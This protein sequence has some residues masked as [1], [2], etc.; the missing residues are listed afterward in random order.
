M[1]AAAANV[2]AF[3]PGKTGQ[4][5]DLTKPGSLLR[6]CR[7]RTIKTL[8]ESVSKALD[9]F[10]DELYE[11]AEQSL[12][13]DSRDFY[14]KAKEEW[15]TLRPRLEQRF[16]ER[17]EEGF[18]RKSRGEEEEPADFS[19]V[20]TAWSELSL[21]ADGDLDES[22]RFTDIAGRIRNGA[23]E[24]LA[25][26]DQRMAVVLDRPNMQSHDNPLS[27][28]AICDAFRS[29]M[30]VVESGARLKKLLIRYFDQGVRFPVPKLY[31]ELNGFLKEHGVLPTIR[32]GRSKKPVSGAGP[33]NGAKAADASQVLGTVTLPIVA[34][35]P[36]TGGATMTMTLPGGVAMPGMG[37][38]TAGGGI[39]DGQDPFAMLQQLMMGA[40]ARGAKGP[41]GA[42][43]IAA[44]AG[45][46]GV[47]TGMPGAGSPAGFG[48]GM[49]GAGG[50]GFAV[51]H[52]GG[53]GTGGLGGGAPGLGVGGGTAGGAPAAPDTGFPQ[54]DGLS[55]GGIAGTGGF[56]GGGVAG[57]G[58]AAGG[59]A[60]GGVAG[61][62]FTGGAL[63]G[64]LTRLQHGDFRAMPSDVPAAFATPDLSSVSLG[65]GFAAA[66]SLEA[67]AAPARNVL[68]ALKGTSFANQLGQM[69]TVTLDIVAMLFDQIFGDPRVPAAMKALIGRLQIPMLKVAVMDKNFFSK[70]NHPARH[71]LD[72]LGELSVGLGDGFDAG[73]ALYQRIESILQR[74]VE[75]FEEDVGIF[76]RTTA[77]L[78]ALI[79]DADK[80]AEQAGKKEARRIQDKE[81]LDVARL[82]AQN[83]VKA[84]VKN[85]ALPRA[86]L[87][88]LATEWMKLLILAY[89]KGGRES[90][91]WQSLVET[92][93]ILVWSM[94][95]KQST[96]ERQRL[97]SVLPG[98]LKRL[99]TGM[100]IIGTQQHA[101][102]RFNS[103]LM[104]CHAK[105]IGGGDAATADVENPLAAEQAVAQR[106]AADAKIDVFAPVEIAPATGLHV[107]EVPMPAAAESIELTEADVSAPAKIQLQEEMRPV[108]A[109]DTLP[110]VVVR[111]PFGEGSIELEEVSFGDLP[112]FKPATAIDGAPAG[113]D[114]EAEPLPQ[115]DEWSELVL[116]F[117][118]GDWIELHE[119][120]GAAVQARLSYVS[121]YRGTYVFTNRKGQKVGEFS[122]FDITSALRSGRM[123]VMANVPL[124]DRAFTGLVGMLRKHAEEAA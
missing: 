76:D 58:S 20:Q 29:A 39:A 1:N 57:G 77:E 40:V 61:G 27:P 122:M 85:Q 82:F 64:S 70:K 16:R 23:D 4:P 104:R 79:Q 17:L 109:P 56:A 87:R 30:S 78:Q 73:S 115:G 121:P 99:T 35:S 120:S 88:F 92:M 47:G 28:M 38:G 41:A 101:R 72:T 51:P 117:K 75:E 26:L 19:N 54:L 13:R 116:Q 95:P 94:T 98:L 93:D 114:I 113:T 63:I 24:E 68:H 7:A 9:T 12:D 123:T 65:G 111:N 90:R 67:G 86:V 49:A 33:S 81:R 34:G 48:G 112:G 22:V 60:T 118:E 102:E 119:E 59:P 83:E 43:G 97:V 25:A 2:I 8:T 18:D 45:G 53:L 37:A 107:E 11:L 84:R 105:A 110:A 44:R 55:G 106:A 21:V 108:V 80:T 10:V 66:A 89:A 74:V 14:L 100:D 69:D 15:P 46:P 36:A 71:M 31:A 32:Y 91:A 52:R 50:A 103:V 5:I 3:P 42:P 6:E 124:F 62:V 96:E